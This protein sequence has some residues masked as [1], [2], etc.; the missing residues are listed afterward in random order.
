MSADID[1]T[2]AEAFRSIYA[3]VLITARDRV[4]LD[5]AVREAAGNASS[6]IL[7]DCEAGLD[8]YVGPDGDP[9]F[10]TPDG[11]PGALVQF[12]VPRFKKERVQALER[13]LLVRISQNVLTCP[14]ATC[15]SPVP[16]E[17][18]YELGRKIAF[19]GDGFQFC[20]ER[21]GRSVWVVPILGGEFVLRPVFRLARRTY[22]REPLVHGRGSRFGP[23]GGRTSGSRRGEGSRGYRPV[24]WR[25]HVERIESRQ[26]LFVHGGQHLRKV[27]PHAPREVGRKVGRA[28]RGNVD[29]GNHSE[30]NRSDLHIPHRPG[31]H[32]RRRR[33]ARPGANFRRKLRRASRQGFHL[34][35]AEGRD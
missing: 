21:F 10:A 9:S 15:F 5:R 4:W 17:P 7:C 26:P 16:D 31:R 22:G 30:R 32:R 29:H 24:S 35:P 20:D 34:S 6:T 27:L 3:P 23:V 14:T 12:H 1:D 8:R 25:N 13:A 18:H 11:R 2:Y 33:Y 19:F 28:G